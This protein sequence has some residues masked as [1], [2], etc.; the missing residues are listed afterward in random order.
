[1]VSCLEVSMATPR[2][3]WF[4]MVYNGTSY[5]NWMIWGY[6]HFWK[7]PF[8]NPQLGFVPQSDAK[9]NRTAATGVKPVP[10]CATENRPTEYHATLWMM[11]SGLIR[12]REVASS[13][14]SAFCHSPAFS[15]AL[16]AELKLSKFGWRW[17]EEISPLVGLIGWFNAHN[18]Q[19]VQSVVR[20]SPVSLEKRLQR[21]RWLQL[22]DS[23]KVQ[24][25]WVL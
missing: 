11:T 5:Q 25:H 1:M 22:E 10:F 16:I 2:F 24:L 18:V 21:N 4:T 12:A 9:W 20:A 17:A 7:R 8:Q 14:Y 15:H 13:R 19:A 3:G 6:R 23:S